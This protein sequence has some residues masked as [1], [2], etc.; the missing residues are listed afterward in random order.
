MFNG[1]RCVSGKS[2]GRRQL[3]AVVFLADVFAAFLAVSEQLPVSADDSFLSLSP[4][5]FI[6]SFPKAPC[7]KQELDCTKG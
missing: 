1:L 7:F 6:H 2:A 3:D 4:F 5:S